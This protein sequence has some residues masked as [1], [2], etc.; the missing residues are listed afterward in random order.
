M[1]AL[2]VMKGGSVESA[3]AIVRGLQALV[4][5]NERLRNRVA[6]LENQTQTWPTEDELSPEMRARLMPEGYGSPRFEDG[7]PVMPGDWVDDDG[8]IMCVDTI[9][10]DGN[11]P[12]LMSPGFGRAIYPRAD[13]RLK[14]PVPLDADDVPILVGE[15]VFGGDGEGWEVTGYRWD[16]APF[17]IEGESRDAEPEV[18]QM[19]PW[20]LTHEGP[21]ANSSQCAPISPNADSWEKLEEDARVLLIEGGELHFGG[22]VFS[23]VDLV[24]RARAL[25]GE[26]E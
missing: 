2:D 4:E 11:G 25:A 17:V 15:T 21:K 1:S 19:K 8:V 6:E 18:R 9:G 7:A 14:R 13:E 12:M 24:R 26:G 16:K 10:F 20:W 5:E 22:R 23:P 3:K